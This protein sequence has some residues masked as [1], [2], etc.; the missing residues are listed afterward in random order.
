MKRTTTTAIVLAIVASLAFAGSAL[1]GSKD[2]LTRCDTKNG[3]VN[4]RFQYSALDPISVNSMDQF[5]AVLT[6][7]SIGL[8]ITLQG[9]V[10]KR[11]KAVTG[12]IKTNRFD[13]KNKVCRV[14]SQK[15]K[16]AK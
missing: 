4:K 7:K 15:F 8:K 3:R 14:P 9:E 5:D 10:K 13:L 16:T 2:V 6:D 12:K 1:A 11:G